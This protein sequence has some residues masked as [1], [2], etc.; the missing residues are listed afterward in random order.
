MLFTGIHLRRP[1]RLMFGGSAGCSFAPHHKRRTFHVLAH[2][3]NDTVLGQAKLSLNRFKR[4]PVFPGHFDDSGD[5]LFSHGQMITP[6]LAISW[7]A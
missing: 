4:S 5:I 7:V 3:L 6:I 2:E 1:Q